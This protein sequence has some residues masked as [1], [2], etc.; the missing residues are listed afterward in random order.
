[1]MRRVKLTEPK[2]AIIEEVE[3]PKPGPGEIVMKIAYSGICGSDLHASLGKHPFVP[4]PA[5]PGH[6]LNAMC[7]FSP[8]PK[9]T[10]SIGLLFNNSPIFLH[11]NLGSEV[12]PSSK[13]VFGCF[14]ISMNL[15]FKY[16]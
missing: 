15:S 9:N 16:L 6:E 5:T 1:M 12:F 2:K 13:L 4:L 14:T 10:T 8:M 7:P 3:I 11:S